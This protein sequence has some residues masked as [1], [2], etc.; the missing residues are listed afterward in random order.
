M[1]LRDFLK[2]FVEP[3]T[4]L[5]LW[6]KIPGGHQLIQQL[7]FSSGVEVILDKSAKSLDDLKTVTVLS[8]I[9]K[10]DAYMVEKDDGGESK[11]YVFDGEEFVDANYL[12]IVKEN[13]I[14]CMDHELLKG[15]V[16][17]S[18]YLDSEVRG[19]TDIVPTATYDYSINI[20]LNI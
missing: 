3:N 13:K 15:D 8:N 11:I 14:I 5:K 12:G 20:V 18:R 17:Q 4:S 1:K 10:F 19:I 7:K 9:K 2:E 6:R 16:W